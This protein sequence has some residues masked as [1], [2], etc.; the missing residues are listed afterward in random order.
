MREAKSLQIDA[1]DCVLRQF[2]LQNRQHED[3]Q[4]PFEAHEIRQAVQKQKEKYALLQNQ[5][6]Q[7]ERNKMKMELGMMKMKGMLMKKRWH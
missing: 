3:L 5:W 7:Q 2:A 6:R 4:Y 1:Q